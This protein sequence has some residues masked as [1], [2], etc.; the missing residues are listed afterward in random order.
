MTLELD[1]VIVPAKDK[2]ASAKRLAERNIFSDR[3][4]EHTAGNQPGEGEAGLA[5]MTAQWLGLSVLFWSSA[6][7]IRILD[8]LSTFVFAMER[9]GRKNRDDR[10]GNANV[11]L[12]DLEARVSPYFPA[13]RKQGRDC[14][15]G[16]VGIAVPGFRRKIAL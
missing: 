16:F 12:P 11:P 10:L 14:R 2:R 3:K 9:H 4:S 5:V 1:H 6:A 13:H 7:G 8:S 15:E